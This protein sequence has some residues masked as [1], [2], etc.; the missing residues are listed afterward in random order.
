MFLTIR[1]ATKGTFTDKWA[2]EVDDNFWTWDNVYPA[3]KKSV[4]FAPPDLTKI[5]PSLN[6]TYDPT[7][8]DDNGG[9]LW[10]SFGNN[11]GAYGPSLGAAMEAAGLDRLQDLD[12]GTLLGYGT[13]KA[14][15]DTRTATRSTAES[16][17][18]QKAATAPNSTIKLYPNAL[19]N[20][21]TFDANKRATG[22]DIMSNVAT[23]PEL[24]YH[25][26]ANKEVILTAGVVR[27]GTHY[28][29]MYMYH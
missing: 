11:Q 23:S 20:R 12:T 4:H 25:L 8:F 18:L 7:A 28:L 15:I 21:I 2:K 1:S 16:S 24:Q 17:F 22:V 5:D 27:G 6:I 19:V 3:Y 10:V 9:P 13:S 29:G 14:T 26:S